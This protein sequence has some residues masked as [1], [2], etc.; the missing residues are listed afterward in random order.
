LG[1]LARV[2]SQANNSSNGATALPSGGIAGEYAPP[3]PLCSPWPPT[4]P[5]EYDIGFGGC[6][7]GRFPM[8]LRYVNQPLLAWAMRKLKRFRAHKVRASRSLQRMARENANLFVH[9]RI[10]MTGTFA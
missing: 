2:T 9:W 4:W 1:E 8:G 6:A 5:V 10:G 3:W 7:R